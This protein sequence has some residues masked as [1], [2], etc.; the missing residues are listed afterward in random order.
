[1]TR[2]GRFAARRYRHAGI[3]S[4]AMMPAGAAGGMDDGAKYLYFS[5]IMNE[6][7]DGDEDEKLA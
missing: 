1:M 6:G 4:P 3:S 7:R 2:I 5:Y